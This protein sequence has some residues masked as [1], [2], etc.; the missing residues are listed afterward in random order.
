MYIVK[1]RCGVNYHVRIYIRASL[2]L[3]YIEESLAE[4]A[5]NIMIP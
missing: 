5:C 4:I 3:Q 2:T 1:T